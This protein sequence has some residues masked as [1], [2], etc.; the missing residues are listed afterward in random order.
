MVG[1]RPECLGGIYRRPFVPVLISGGG[2]LGWLAVIAPSH[3]YI[4]RIEYPILVVLSVDAGT[5]LVLGVL[6]ESR[7]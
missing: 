3:H 4:M 1:Q 5:G 2:R 6:V 7:V